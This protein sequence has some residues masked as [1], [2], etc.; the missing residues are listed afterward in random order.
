MSFRVVYRADLRRSV[1]SAARLRGRVAANRSAAEP[2][3]AD[4]S[5]N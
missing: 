1:A 2:R 4:N 3:D 5:V